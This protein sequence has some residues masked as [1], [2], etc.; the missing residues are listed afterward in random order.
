MAQHE[1]TILVTNEKPLI[2]TEKNG[3]WN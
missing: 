3:I 2:L 1:H